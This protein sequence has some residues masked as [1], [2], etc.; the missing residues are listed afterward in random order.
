MTAAQGH[1]AALV[2]AAGR[3]SRMGQPKQL[4][5]MGGRTVLE[6]VLKNIRAAGITEVVLVLGCEAQRIR[7]EVSEDALGEVRVVLN[8]RYG[9]GMAGSLRI[10]LTEVSRTA[11]AAL[12]VLGDQPLVRPE[13]LLRLTEIPVTDGT[14]IV[15]PVLRGKRGNPVRISRALFEEAMALQGD[16][17]CRALFSAHADAILRVEVEDEGIL[18]DLDEPGDYER[19]Q[20]GTSLT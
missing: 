18:L 6:R 17:G 12:I 13:T 11:A 20:R 4:L 8:P 10:G 7:R 5:R 15:I 2:L 14:G 16:V 9:Q 19:L 3:S 1:V